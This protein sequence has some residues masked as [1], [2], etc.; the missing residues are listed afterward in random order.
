MIKISEI[1]GW[2]YYTIYNQP[3]FYLM[4]IADY[5]KNKK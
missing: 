3:D 2:D 1:F 5:L 4:A